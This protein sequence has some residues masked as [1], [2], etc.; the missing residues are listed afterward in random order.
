M[1][2]IMLGY[3]YYARNYTTNSLYQPPLFPQNKGF[4]KNSEVS[5]LLESTDE[6]TAVQKRLE[7]CKTQF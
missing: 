3:G 6:G 2:Q 4:Y 7:F 5:G 1:L